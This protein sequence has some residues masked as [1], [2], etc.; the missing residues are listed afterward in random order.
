MDYQRLL[1]CDVDQW[2]QWRIN[3]PTLVPALS[4]ADLSKCY[5]FEID[6]R[7][8]N[9]RGA[10][11]SRAC[12]IGADLRNADL[13]GA[14]LS[15]AYLSEANLASANLRQANLSSANL[16]SANLSHADLFQAQTTEADLEA[17]ILT[18]T[19]LAPTAQ[20][21]SPLPNP[22]VAKR[23]D[24]LKVMAQVAQVSGHQPDV[25]QA[26]ISKTRQSQTIVQVKT[27]GFEKPAHLDNHL[28]TDCKTPPA[29]WN[30]TLLE[31]CQRKLSEYFIDPVVALVLDDIIKLHRP[32][33]PSQ[34]IDLVADKIPD[35]Q[36]AIRFRHS[37]LPSER[38]E[39]S[40]SPNAPALTNAFIE[41]CQQSLIDDIGPMAQ[42]IVDEI[43]ATHHPTTP[44]Q[45]VKLIANEL[46]P[47]Q[48][49]IFCHQAL[50]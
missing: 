1:E 37:V 14:D 50:L 46:P 42:V 3:N 6:L 8:A 33:T 2:N 41:K 47:A 17:A 32:R 28:I 7:G 24:Q 18:G 39:R 16:S 11:L 26:S 44:N 4:G 15:N 36:E 35:P 21:L 49:E 45:L 5:L 25:S 10:N 13:S 23:P 9:L 27:S 43:I 31:Q 20:N 22:A 38:V 30:P 29:A 48:A 34:L 12:L 19:C 40:Y